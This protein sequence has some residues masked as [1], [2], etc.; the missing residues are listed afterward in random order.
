MKIAIT[1]SGTDLDAPVDPRFGRA[2]AFIL[3]DTETGE[4]SLLDNTQ[5]LQAA[6][7]AGIQAASSVANAGA[8]AVLTGNCGPRAFQ[9]LSAGGVAVYAGAEG[10]VREAIEKLKAGEL[11]Q[12]GGATVGA[13]FGTSV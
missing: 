6:Q 7:G 11:R 10:T 13:H 4:W 1:T 9:T 2:K 5:N 12:A 8:Q 3:Y